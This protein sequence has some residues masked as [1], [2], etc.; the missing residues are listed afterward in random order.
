MLRSV[1]HLQIISCLSF[2]IAT[3]LIWSDIRANYQNRRQNNRDYDREYDL[4]YSTSTLDDYDEVQLKQINQNKPKTC[5]PV[6]ENKNLLTHR[7]IDYDLSEPEYSLDDIDSIFSEGFD[8]TAMYWPKNCTANK[9]LAVIIPYRNRPDHIRISI[10]FLIEI[11]KKQELAFKIFIIEQIGEDTTFNRGKLLNFGYLKVLEDMQKSLDESHHFK[12]HK[13]H[14]FSCMVFHDIDMISV[15]EQL[16]YECDMS[17]PVHLANKRWTTN[18][19]GNE[20]HLAQSFG[21]VSSLTLKMFKNCNGYSNLYW[22][23]GGEDDDLYRRLLANNY[24]ILRRKTKEHDNWRMVEHKKTHAEEDNQLNPK[25][26]ELKNMAVE[27]MM[28]DGLSDFEY[29]EVSR[30]LTKVFEMITVDVGKSS[31]SPRP[32]K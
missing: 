18:K 2:L 28:I 1:F 32:R 10:P 8:S 22:G 5:T 20:A 6:K 11:L 30:K 29:R 3:Y 4:Y 19:L 24:T 16:S 21:A 15:D 17:N 31:E 13:P 23:W 27:R 9:P 12:P 7:L 26:F 14:F 25:R